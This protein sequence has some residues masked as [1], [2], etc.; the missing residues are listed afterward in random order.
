MSL[1]ILKYKNSKVWLTDKAI[2][3]KK[4]NKFYKI[5]YKEIRAFEFRAP[6]CRGCWDE[7][8]EIENIQGK[9]FEF[10]DINGKELFE[11]FNEINPNYIPKKRTL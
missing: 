4:F 11:K 10:Q 3:L 5:S 8:L 2:I 9:N 6:Y 1:S 7:A